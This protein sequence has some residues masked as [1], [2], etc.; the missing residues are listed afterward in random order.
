MGNLHGRGRIQKN[1]YLFWDDEIIIW[2]HL[3][4][5]RM[6]H[7]RYTPKAINGENGQ[8]LFDLTPWPSWDMLSL[9]A[10]A[11]R[12]VIALRLYPNGQESALLEIARQTKELSVDGKPV[13]ADDLE[14]SLTAALRQ[15]S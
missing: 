4:E 15:R 6:S 2:V 3:T 9:E 13:T 7:W 10:E 14:R 5:G 12:L 8:T 11:D 1:L